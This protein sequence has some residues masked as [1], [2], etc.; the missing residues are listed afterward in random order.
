MAFN[1]EVE[2]KHIILVQ[3]RTFEFSHGLGQ[4]QTSERYGAGAGMGRMLETF[5]PA[6]VLTRT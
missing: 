4:E 3:L 6:E 5:Q 1:F 2:R